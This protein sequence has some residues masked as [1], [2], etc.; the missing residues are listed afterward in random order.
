MTV[1]FRKTAHGKLASWFNAS[2]NHYQLIRCYNCS[3]VQLSYKNR[4]GFTAQKQQHAKDVH[5]V[6]LSLA[7]NEGIVLFS[8]LSV[9]GYGSFPQETLLAIRK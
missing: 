7:V 1:T 2:T 3:C 4:V 9:P 5:L 6:T 8:V